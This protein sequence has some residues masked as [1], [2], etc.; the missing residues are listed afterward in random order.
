MRL[1]GCRPLGWLQLRWEDQVRKGCTNA[2]PKYRMVYLSDGKKEVARSVID[3][4]IL[5]VDYK[6]EDIFNDDIQLLPFL[7]Y[8]IL[9]L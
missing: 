1:G 7:E 2:G 9:H 5:I 8:S 4:M 6:E 3:C